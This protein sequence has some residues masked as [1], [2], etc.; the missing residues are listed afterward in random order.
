MSNQLTIG[1]TGVAGGVGQSILKALELS[2][3]DLKIVRID[4]CD[5]AGFYFPSKFPVENMKFKKDILGNID[6]QK[7]IDEYNLDAI[8]PGSDY[9]ILDL[10]A[11]KGL[12]KD[13]F[14]F[15]VQNCHLLVSDQN[16]VNACSDKFETQTLL[17]K[18]ST[19]Y[20]HTYI[21]PEYVMV[22]KPRRGSGSV[23]FKRLKPNITNWKDI[24]LQEYIDGVEY[25]CS[26]FNPK[27]NNP[28]HRFTF[29][30][31]REL[32][33]GATYKA[34]YRDDAEI[35]ELLLWI[36]EC[37]KPVGP[38]NVQLRR[39]RNNKL[40]VIELNCRCSGT[41]AYRAAC[42]FNEPD[43]LIRSYVLGEE[44]KQMNIKPLRMLR[45]WNE[46]YDQ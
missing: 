4:C 13:V 46:V 28:S 33:H 1:V 43:M 39:D 21:N 25:T 36:C 17:S 42:G 22:Q 23:G 15:K 27:S 45:Y 34:W 41:T 12:Y 29:I 37:L 31:K 20:P 11:F 24:V 9:D 2:D 35:E 26:V 30:S 10:S 6:W 18:Y 14:S 32:R 38:L 3:L 5:G 7:I 40:W 44:L 8:I 19:P 16:L